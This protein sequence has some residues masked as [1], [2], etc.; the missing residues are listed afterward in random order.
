MATTAAPVRRATLRPWRPESLPDNVKRHVHDLRYV[1]VDEVVGD[2]VTLTVT[3]WPT[4]DGFGRVRFLGAQAS[5]AGTGHLLVHR[6]ELHECLYR[7]WIRRSPRPGDVFAAKVAGV[8]ED[9]L[10]RGEDVALDDRLRLSTALPGLVCDITAESRN[11]AKLAFYAGLAGVQPIEQAQAQ[12][13]LPSGHATE[14][15]GWGA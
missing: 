8:V 9:R 6:R 7:G 5:Q 10:R 4:V 15:A 1:A 13:Q 14:V 11:V 12:G 2:L 3:P